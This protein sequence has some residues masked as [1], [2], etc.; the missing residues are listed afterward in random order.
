MHP[1]AFY[2]LTLSGA[3][4]DY[5][6]HDKEVLAIF[7]VFK[8]WWH[9]L[10]SPHHMIDIITNHKNLEYFSST[11]VLTC[12]QACWSEYLSAFTMIICFQPGKL[13][14]KP[15][16]LTQCADYYLKRGDRDYMLANLQNI[17]PVFMQ[18]QL[19]TSL[20][21]MLLC[22]VVLDASALVDSSIP[23]IDTTALAE[24][25]KSTYLDNPIAKCKYNSCA[26]GS[27]SPHFSLSPL[28]LCLLDHHIY[29]PEH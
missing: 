15:D 2:S 9:Y 22:V 4:L 27:P 26:K 29:I 7:K 23:I 8:N 12:C 1:V 10:K 18:E 13:G 16:T 6:I 3:E 5:D 20:C 19:A 28:G 11:K 17:C 14:E 21:A 24:D 25:I